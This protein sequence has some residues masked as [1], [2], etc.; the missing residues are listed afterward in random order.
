MPWIERKA[1]VKALHRFTQ[2]LI[3]YE[4]DLEIA[5]LLV[6]D[7]LAGAADDRSLCQAIGG[8]ANLYPRLHACRNTAQARKIVGLHLKRTLHVAFIK[9][10]YEDFSEFLSTSLS[11]AALAGIDA[12][13]FAGE[14]RLDLHAKEIL[15]AGSW[16][17]VIRLISDKIFR[18]LENERNTRMLINKMSVR[19]GLRLEDQPLNDA[20]PYLDARHILVHRDGKPD[21]IYTRSYPDISIVKGE[22]NLN[23]E[24][25]SRARNAV[26]ALA[27]HI[28]V[29]M[30]EAGLVRQQDMAGQRRE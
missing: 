10:L 11:R 24:F 1:G 15:Q 22:I 4:T 18:A 20:M 7:F 13:R 6:R 21:E 26:L 16:D 12:A 2:R 29:K 8:R 14:A 30:V 27:E 17:A 9:E 28:D 23:F 25:V 5:D 19:V 3:A